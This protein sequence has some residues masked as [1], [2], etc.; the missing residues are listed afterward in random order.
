MFRL[1]LTGQVAYTTCVAVLTLTSVI[2]LPTSLHAQVQGQG[3]T[4]SLSKSATVQ[5]REATGRSLRAVAVAADAVAP[6]VA[7][8][9]SAPKAANPAPEPNT[10]VL[11]GTGSLV[12]FGL[13]TRRRARS[14][15]PT[16]GA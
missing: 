3:T 1:P 14:L 13:Y 5:P 11:L 12:L 8:S 7:A 9:N 4:V 6:K 10:L 15:A 2:S 16:E